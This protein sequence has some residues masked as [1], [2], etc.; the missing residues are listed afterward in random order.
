L[1]L[2]DEFGADLRYAARRLRRSLGFTAVATVSLALAI[3]ANTTIF[4]LAKQLLYDRLAVPNAENLR[5]LSWTG[6]EE[7]VAVHGIW[8]DYEPLPGGRVTS[9][10]FSYEAFQRL[11]AENRELEDLFAFK[12]EG[13][14]A[15]IGGAAQRVRGEMVSGNYYADLDVRPVL[16]RGITPADDAKP[17]QG[18]VAAIGYGL[19]EREFGRSPAVLGQ[20]IRVNE[21][22]LTIVGVNPKGFTSA[23]DVQTPADVFIPLSMQPVVS[24]MPGKTPPLS[25]PNLWWVNIMGRA[26]VGISDQTAQAGLDAQLAAIVRGTMPVKEGEDLPRMDL[27][28]GSRGLFEQRHTFAKPMAVL[29]TMVGLVLL[30]ACANISNLMLA[31]GTQRQREISVRLALGAGRGRILRQMLVESLLLSTMGGA[32]GLLAAYFG[33]NAIPRMIENSWEQSDLHVHFDWR[34]FGFTAAVTMLTGILFGLTPALAAA[35]RDVNRSLKEGALTATR[36]RKAWGGRALVGFQIA[37][38]TLLVIGAGLFLRTLAGLSSVNVGFRTDHLLLIEIN[39]ERTQ[40]PPG[41]D[42]DLHQRLEAAFAGVPGVE[43]VTAAVPVYIADDRMRR[44]FLVEGQDEHKSEAEFFNVVGNNFFRTLGIPIVAGRGFGSQD[45]ATSLKVGVINQSLARKSF[46]NRNPVGQRFSISTEESDGRRGREWIQ[47]VGVCA[48]TRYSSLR[49]E[50]PPQFFLLYGQ[51]REVGALNYEIRTAMQPE[52]VLP[53]LRHVARQIDPNLPFGNVR[54]QDQQIAAAMQ[55][56]CIFAA[57][58]SSFGLLALALAAVG[59]YGIMAYAVANRT[60]E[61]GIR[62]ALGAQQRQVLAMILREASWISVAGVIVGLGAALILARLVKA[63]LYGLQPTDP[64]SLCAGALLLVVV[65][66]AASWI[67]AQ[68]AAS[69]QPVEA[70]RHE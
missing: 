16:G 37:L 34:V 35:R 59:I 68:R 22:P 30:L 65:G 24:P 66:L 62:L 47:I 2:W 63:M 56:E 10:A 46:P 38:S 57:M 58:A 5:L 67:P 45:T 14:N 20:V 9:T 23:K 1:R 4:S 60:N 49:A 43:T 53:A 44:D 3:G 7:H 70:L 36:R 19:W 31:R 25:D 21:V 40:Y 29:M 64:V 51:Q 41:K 61:I 15:T 17:G 11:R 13:M 27:R 8:G 50:P 28:D 42:V 33:R 32:F 26:K 52:A 39:P 54:T 6:T 48:D 12:R 69:V 55:Q 18:A